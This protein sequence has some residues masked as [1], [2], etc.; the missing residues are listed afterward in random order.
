MDMQQQGLN[1]YSGKKQKKLVSK[2]VQDQENMDMEHDDVPNVDYDAEHVPDV[3]SDSDVDSPVQ[4]TV[5]KSKSGVVN[6][7][8]TH[9]YQVLQHKKNHNGQA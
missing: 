4:H 6:F 1:P 7:K 2:N 3:Q 5:P 9:F 8:N